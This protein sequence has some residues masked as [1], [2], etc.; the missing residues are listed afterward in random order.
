RP[1]TTERSRRVVNVNA[2]TLGL[3]CRQCS[4]ARR[5][6]RQ[7]GREEAMLDDRTPPRQFAMEA[8][9]RFGQPA[10]HGKEK[11]A[12][13]SV[14]STRRRTSSKLSR[15]I[16]ADTDTMSEWEYRKIDLNDTPRKETDIDIL[17]HAGAEGWELVLIMSHHIAYLKRRVL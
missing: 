7:Q 11:S 9:T 15:T 1:S 17:N 2:A 14:G 4:C 6:T 10:H 13:R 12:K 3:D 16:L 8:S 5:S